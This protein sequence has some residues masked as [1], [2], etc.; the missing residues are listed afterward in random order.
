ML[1]QQLQLKL[2]LNISKTKKLVP[3]RGIGG[4]H[5]SFNLGSG[6]KE[7]DSY[8]NLGVKCT[9]HTTLAPSSERNRADCSS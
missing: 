3:A 2:K 5:P 9:G 7:T 1:Q 8:M 6:N 4:S